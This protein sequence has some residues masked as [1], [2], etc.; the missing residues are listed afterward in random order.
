[1]NENLVADN[2][3]LQSWPLGVT[4]ANPVGS[5]GWSHNARF[6]QRMSSLKTSINDGRRNSRPVFGLHMSQVRGETA[7][8]RGLGSLRQ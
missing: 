5:R 2:A 7:V 8:R 4:S 6:G 3:L 1:V